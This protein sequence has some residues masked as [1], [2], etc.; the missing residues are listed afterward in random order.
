MPGRKTVIAGLLA[1]ALAP[2]LGAQ[3]A[4]VPP[5]FDHAGQRALEWTRRVVELGPR[6]S[7]SPAH[8]EQ[9]R[10]IARTLRPLLKAAEGSLN[11]LN[12]NAQTPNGSVAMSNIIAK[13]P[14]TSERTVVV[15]GHYDTFHRAG[16]HFVGA[17]DGGSSTGF[18]LALAE[19]L[20]AEAKGKAGSSEAAFGADTPSGP[21]DQAVPFKRK[22]S[23]WLV[24]FDGEESFVRW[25]PTDGTY[26]SRKLARTWV[27]DGTASRIQALINV[28]MI[29]DRDLR[30]LPEG[31][32]TL[33]LRQLIWQAA[34]RLGYGALFPPGP[35]RHIDDDHVPFVEA[36]IPAVDLI[37]LRYGPANR[38]WHTEEDTLDKLSAK[39]FAIVM[40]VVVGTLGV[41]E[42]R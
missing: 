21:K 27:E 17:N 30:L 25:S 38:Y 26:G 1:G 40:R 3:E 20:A 8:K 32:S 24:F 35:L 23:V 12:F 16:L 15:S 29:G 22:N 14:G 34:S 37:D 5:P 39:S 18:L 36:G 9:Q 42:V 41:L 10:L 33:W 6:P 2:W 13:F 31:K 4:S 19:L 11:L 7:G 28:D